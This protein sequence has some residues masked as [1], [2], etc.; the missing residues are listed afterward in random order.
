MITEG[1]IGSALATD[2]EKVFRTEI[3]CQWVDQLADYPID[4]A[5]WALLEDPGSSPAGSLIPDLTAEGFQV[6]GMAGRALGQACG[7]FFD[8]VTEKGLRHLGQ[9]ELT[10][11]LLGAAKRPVVDAW[12]WAR[13][14]STS[15]I[16]PLVAATLAVS[17]FLL[18]GEGLGP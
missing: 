9:P 12:A 17:G 18:F 11:A 10:G 2:P 15:N 1:A 6:E 5:V 14:T 16:S 3:L 7:Q 4:P 13:R 8:L